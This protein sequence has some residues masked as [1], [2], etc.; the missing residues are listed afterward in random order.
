MA[1][2]QTKEIGIAAPVLRADDDQD[3]NTDI[4]G[5]SA[6]YGSEPTS[7][8]VMTGRGRTRCQT[9]LS[10]MTS[11]TNILFQLEL[12]RVC[13]GG[14]QANSMTT[15]GLIQALAVCTE[16]LSQQIDIEEGSGFESKEIGCQ[17]PEYST[18]KELM[19]AN[20]ANPQG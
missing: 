19:R 2:K 1:T 3:G 11:I 4:A 6:L 10:G 9:A 13:T 14:I 17:S 18:L 12:D 7:G 16:F 5:Y 20:T 15:T 8:L